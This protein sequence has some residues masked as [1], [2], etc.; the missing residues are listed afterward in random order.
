M[1]PISLENV[2]GASKRRG[3]RRD[4]YCVAPVLELFNDEGWDESVFDF[5][6]CRLP[7]VVAA[8]PRQLL[9]EAPHD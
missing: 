1:D 4:K 2:D 3:D 8:V 5:S 9:G 6:Q 7:G